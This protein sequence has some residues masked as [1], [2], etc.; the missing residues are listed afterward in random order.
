MREIWVV[1]YKK[2]KDLAQ[3]SAMLSRGEHVLGTRSKAKKKSFGV[4]VPQGG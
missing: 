2:V 1:K 3:E 4:H